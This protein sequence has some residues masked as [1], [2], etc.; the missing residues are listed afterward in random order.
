MPP[1]GLQ[2][3]G[4]DYDESLRHFILWSGARLTDPGPCPVRETIRHLVT[5]GFVNP[6][7]LA[8]S[9]LQAV[10][11]FFGDYLSVHRPEAAFRSISTSII[12]N[13]HFMA[14]QY[15]STYWTPSSLPAGH[16]NPYVG[17]RG[18]AW[19]VLALN[20]AQASSLLPQPKPHTELPRF[21]FSSPVYLNDKHRECVRR[22]YVCFHHHPAAGLSCRMG[23]YCLSQHLDTSDKDLLCRWNRAASSSNDRNPEHLTFIPTIRPPLPAT[24]IS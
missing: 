23:D 6:C 17:D 22:E 2:Y 15:L 8:Q 1:G 16:S 11:T 13:L 12:K 7:I 19:V 5:A 10:L 18:P 9:S 21:S 14:S 4:Q 24:T 3:G 20:P